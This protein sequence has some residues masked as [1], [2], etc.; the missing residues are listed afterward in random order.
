MGMAFGRGGERRWVGRLADRWAT[1]MERGL[2]VDSSLKVLCE[3]ESD[4]TRREVLGRVVAA[5]GAGIPLRESMRWFPERFE[6]DFLR[7]VEAGERSGDL[8]R[9]LRLAA[10]QFRRWERL[11]RRWRMALI[12]P[13]VVGLAGL[14]VVAFLAGW[15]GP[16]FLGVVEEMAGKGNLPALTRWILVMGTPGWHWVAGLLVVV[17]LRVA[18]RRWGE[19]F[20]LPFLADLREEEGRARWLRSW[21]TFL[22]SGFPLLPALE[23]ATGVVG[24]RRAQQTLAAVCTAMADGERVSE[25][26]RRQRVLP[27]EYIALIVLGEEGGGM[28]EALL[29]AARLAEDKLDRRL[30]VLMALME[31]ALCLALSLV[32]G[33][34]VVGMI[35]PLAGM[36]E[37]LGP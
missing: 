30:E 10:D 24:G 11:R 25:A 18:F 29:E 27:E 9:T 13:L 23:S 37:S 5:L 19:R 26:M 17:L 15:V 20:P 7:L 33:L 35:L 16:R 12:Y 14:A 6:G 31:P 21:A 36:W 8:G 34:V 3:G 1:L 2:P 28:A 22:G 32:V 4:P